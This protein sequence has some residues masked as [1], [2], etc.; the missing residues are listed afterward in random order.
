MRLPGIVARPKLASGMKSAFMSN[1][2]HA[3]MANEAF[4]C[5]VSAET[6]MWFMSVQS[7]AKNFCHAL[8][9]D[10]NALPESRTLTL[11]ALRLNMDMLVSG[12]YS[13]LDIKEKLVTYVA[14]AE[15]ERGFGGYPVLVTKTADELAWPLLLH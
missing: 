1:V 2:F 9:L 13:L 10:T 5:P 3:L 7:V 6:T 4:V 14:D 15:L 11:P 8:E 12:L